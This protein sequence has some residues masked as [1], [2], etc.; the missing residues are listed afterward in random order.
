MKTAALLLALAAPASASWY[1]LDI[2]SAVAEAA[3]ST[4]GSVAAQKEKA[5]FQR[6]PG[7]D[8]KR[9][10]YQ[11]VVKRECVYRCEDDS[12]YRA[13]VGRGSVSCAQLV[14]VRR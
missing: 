7:R 8:F 11:R 12:E 9:C 1:G 10:T 6:W 2:E 13:P 4:R 5:S 14:W 3:R